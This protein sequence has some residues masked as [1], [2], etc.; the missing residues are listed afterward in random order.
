MIKSRI[1]YLIFYQLILLF[2]ACLTGCNI[3]EELSFGPS[4]TA[5][6]SPGPTRDNLATIIF[7]VKIPAD[8]PTDQPILLSVLD[9]VTGL[10]LNAKR[11]PMK[12]EEP[13]EYSLELSFPV[14]S[15][16][17]YRYSRRGIIL[18]E[19][20]T[21][22]GRSVRYRMVHVTTPGE[23]HDIISR[24]ND[25]TFNQPTGRISGK[26]IN[27][28]TGLPIPNVLVTAGGAQAFTTGDGHFLIEGLPPGTH[29]LVALTMDGSYPT[30]QQGALVAEGSNTPVSI[31]L[32]QS[33]IVDI[34][35][36]LKVP[37]DTPPTVPIRI[38]GNIWQFGNTFADLAGGISTLS[39]RMPTITQVDEHMYGIILSLPAGTD[40]KYKYTLGDGFWNTERTKDGSWVIRQLIIPDDSITVED[41]IETWQLEGDA[42]ITFDINVPDNTPDNESVYIQFNPYGWTEPIPMWSLGE[43][44]WA[45]IL[46]SPLDMLDRL[47]YRYCRAGQCGYADDIR[48]PGSF[49]SGKVIKTTGGV[50]AFADQIENWAWWGLSTKS[51]IDLSQITVEESHGDSFQAGIEFLEAFHPSWISRLPYSMDDV[52]HLNANFLILTPSWTF[53]RNNPPILEPVSGQNPMGMDTKAMIQAANEENLITGLRPVAIFPTQWDEWWSN[54][55]R[56]FSWWVSWFDRY[57]EFIHHH[58]IIAETNNVGSLILGG[59]WMSPAYPKGTLVDGSPSGVPPDADSRYRM[60][61][62]EIRQT[63]HG[64]VGWVLTFPENVVNPPDFITEVDFL[65]ILWDEALTDSVSP[66]IGEMRSAAEDMINSD[67]FTLWQN[68]QS[69]DKVPDFIL[70]VAYPSIKGG[71]TTCLADPHQ[72]CIHPS[73]LNY[74]AP[75][76]PLLELD[77]GIQERTYYAILAA[78]SKHG[79]IKGVV[80]RG[81]YP[82]ALLQDKSISIHGK[83]AEEVLKVWF[84]AFLDHSN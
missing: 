49:T 30:F 69:E 73:S 7:Y 3:L 11:Y 64:K 14:G 20:H 74:P 72:E 2:T 41:D 38:A 58:A 50:Q 71:S 56:D 84:Q 79:W 53:T 15:I 36:I 33:K 12:T 76:F 77:L 22:D 13:G 8:T 29:N 62:D 63:Y 21:T 45:Y 46:Y 75:D 25:T 51:D 44:R 35:F 10:A 27:K 43:E 67:L 28:T 23:V 17:K 66:T 65:Y 59:D 81:Y 39:N 61:I 31:Q 26:I 52:T 48:T 18:A 9:E 19:E 40:L 5:T 57:E 32:T 4:E 83:P 37:E 78:I 70:S 68:L 34:T 55:P 47:G 6:P 24:W 54:A 1:R 16:V 42:P 82:P 80:S 60:I